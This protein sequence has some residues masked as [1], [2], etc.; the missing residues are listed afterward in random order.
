[1]QMI[2][3]AMEKLEKS[4]AEEQE[5]AEDRGENPHHWGFPWI[6]GAQRSRTGFSHLRSCLA[7]LESR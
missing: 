4:I 1:M 7:S 2:I 5:K 6:N 3:K